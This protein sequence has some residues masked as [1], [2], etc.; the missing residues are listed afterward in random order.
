MRDIYTFDRKLAGK[1][2]KVSA[3]LV[4]LALG[5]NFTQQPDTQ[6]VTKR[7]LTEN[8]VGPVNYA[9]NFN[10]LI[11]D[12][13]D[14]FSEIVA[15]GGTNNLT[16]LSM[17]TYP[18]I[19]M[20]GGGK[21]TLFHWDFA[22]GFFED[23]DTGYLDGGVSWAAQLSLQGNEAGGFWELVYPTLQNMH[24]LGDFEVERAYLEQNMATSYDSRE[25]RYIVHQ[26][27][28]LTFLDAKNNSVRVDFSMNWD[29]NVVQYTSTFISVSGFTQQDA[30]LDIPAF[31]ATF[32][33]TFGAY[34]SPALHGVFIPEEDLFELINEAKK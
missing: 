7:S 4:M 1:T 25:Q 34:S 31:I 20:G 6:M 10:F 33:A 14:V 28:S 27:F 30:S 11:H 5:Y 13:Q 3:I 2:L 26:G 32:R 15:Q 18:R 8:P 12:I 21:R 19:N 16:Q 24:D 17:T 29:R 22:S 23:R 9:D